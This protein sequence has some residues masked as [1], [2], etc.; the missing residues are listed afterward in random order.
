[1]SSLVSAACVLIPVF[2]SGRLSNLGCMTLDLVRWVRVKVLSG[3]LGSA[4]D[5]VKVGRVQTPARVPLS[6]SIYW[7]SPAV[8]CLVIV[9]AELGGAVQH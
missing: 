4:L 3:K 6:N 8:F 2:E 9:R 5:H 1:M 7:I